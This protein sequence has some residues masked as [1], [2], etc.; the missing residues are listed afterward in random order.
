M[1]LQA[2]PNVLASGCAR[3]DISRSRSRIRRGQPV[4]AA[5]LSDAFAGLYERKKD[6]EEEFQGGAEPPGG[7]KNVVTNSPSLEKVVCRDREDDKLVPYRSLMKEEARNR[8]ELAKYS[9]ATD[10]Y[11]ATPLPF[12]IREEPQQIVDQ[13]ALR[14]PMTVPVQKQMMGLS[15]TFSSKR[16]WPGNADQ[17]KPSS[18]STGEPVSEESSKDNKGSNALHSA[19]TTN[20][21]PWRHRRSTLGVQNVGGG[22]SGSMS[23]QSAA[24]S[25]SPSTRGWSPSEDEKEKE[26]EAQEGESDTCDSVDKT[27]LDISRK[28]APAPPEEA[29]TPGNGWDDDDNEL[30]AELELALEDDEPGVWDALDL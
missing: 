4:A 23:L 12:I 29:V 28:P 30:D 8:G 5:G 6:V 9:R 7:D 13:K 24:S 15:R 18:E 2:L 16:L 26:E 11:S 22:G 19:P 21:R 25:T 14:A 10:Y 27:H 17:P 20:F 3:H 1:Q